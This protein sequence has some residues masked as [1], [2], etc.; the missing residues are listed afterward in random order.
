MSLTPVQ[1]SSGK[2]KLGIWVR[3]DTQGIGTVTY[4]D[5]NGKFGALGHGISDS[6]TGELVETSGGNLYDT[7][8]WELKKEK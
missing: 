8:I 6:D 2:Y 3:D 1:D 7:Q 5:L 4:M